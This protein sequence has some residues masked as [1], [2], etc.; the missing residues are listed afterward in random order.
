MPAFLVIDPTTRQASTSHPQ[1]LYERTEKLL[2]TVQSANFLPELDSGSFERQCGGSWLGQCSWIAIFLVPSA[3]LGSQ[4]ASRRALRRFREA[5][6]SQRQQIECFFLR[7]DSP[8]ASA[9]RQALDPLLSHS[10]LPEEVAKQNT[11]V[12]AFAG[13]ALKAIVF[14]KTLLDR[15]LAQRDLTQWLAR[16]HGARP[17]W[18]QF[19]VTLGAIPQLLGPEQGLAGPRGVIGKIL[20]FAGGQWS[21]LSQALHD[22]GSPLLQLLIFGG[23]FAYPLLRSMFDG[24]G[25]R[26]QAPRLQD[27][28]EVRISGLRQSTEYNGLRARVVACMP[29]DPNKFQGLKYKVQLR[30]LGGDEKVLAIRE[31]NLLTT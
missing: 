10:S 7:H 16:L 30:T 18:S 6:R 3:A 17:E 22:S 31:E 28:Q 12:V 11:W 19:E 23:L 15:E 24:H 29:P 4:E 13:E 25:Q 5:C 20:D 2:A 21:L 9:W 27:G 14:D 26:A 1:L 8:A